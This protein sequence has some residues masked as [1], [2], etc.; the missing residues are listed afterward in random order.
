MSAPDTPSAAAST[1]TSTRTRLH[2]KRLWLARAVWVVVA[3]LGL[4]VSI[5]VLYAFN[6]NMRV[7]GAGLFYGYDPDSRE[8]IV[9]YV[10]PNSPAA[11][12]GLRAGDVLLAV[13]GGT[14]EPGSFYW[15]AGE[16]GSTL[17][18]TVR[19]VD[20]EIKDDTITRR[21]GW[22]SYPTV[23]ALLAGLPLDLYVGYLVAVEAVFMLISAAVAAIVFWHRSDD[24]MGMLGSLALLLWLAFS[25]SA[26]II[27]FG[28]GFL[29][30][31]W[32]SLSNIVVR[33][34]L[35]LGGLA[36]GLFVILAPDG[37]FVPRWSWPLVIA[38]ATLAADSAF[39]RVLPNGL[40]FALF[41]PVG[42]SIVACQV[43]RYARVSTQAQRQQTKWMVVGL[44]TALIG[45]IALTFVAQL[46]PWPYPERLY[47]GMAWFMVREFPM[48][49]LPVCI[50]IAILRY[51][52]WDVDLV[53]NRG[54]VYA[55]LT[56]VLGAIFV[57]GLFLLQSVLG[58]VLGSEQTTT[59]ALISAVVIVGL[60]NPARRRLQSFVDRRFYHLRLDLNQLAEAQTAR[61][62]PSP[63]AL[64]GTK[65]GAYEV[66]EVLGRGGMGEVY[67]GR[68]TGLDRAV[69]IKVLPPQFAMNAEFRARFEREAKILASLRHPNIVNVIDFGHANDVHFMVMEFISGQALNEYLREHGPM[70][71]D[72]ALPIIH[73]LTGALD[74]AH[75]QGLVHRDVKPSNVMLQAVTSTGTSTARQRAILMDFGITKLVTGSTG[76]TQ[77]G[78]AV[79]TLDYMAPEQIMSAREVDRRAD[80][81]ALGIVV[82]QMLTGELPFKGNSTG[83]LLFAHLQQPPPDPRDSREGIP[84][85]V[86]KAI[87][88][89]MAKTP[90]DRFQ[91]A[92]EFAAALS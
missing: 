81:Y 29:P 75:E 13:N 58:A 20:G 40:S 52:L 86:A 85:H 28:A 51:R 78:G 2:G 79:G 65:L 30:P 92:G 12:T 64:S 39:F 3:A 48:L 71:L 55:A 18:L 24:W 38:L 50:G 36:F 27:I 76:L 73:D 33:I 44:G 11:G 77:T 16:L 53:I 82:Y 56:A 80:V 89:A 9:R 26:E 63:G 22:F 6:S 59:A 34:W 83:Q 31:S 46:I 14:I 8:T 7:S 88:K 70:T 49:A 21:A 23:G 61:A 69:A 10:V 45:T 62:I 72:G 60:F 67:K 37:Q 17:T 84:P 68:Q 42:L 74:Y 57:I 1:D 32:Q 90:E 5:F 54:L 66:Q 87:M 4:T 15:E 91:S 41:V 19:S 25:M 35:F 47:V 43:Y